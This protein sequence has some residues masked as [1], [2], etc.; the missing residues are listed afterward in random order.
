MRAPPASCFAGA[1]AARQPSAQ[2]SIFTRSLLP[3]HPRPAPTGAIPGDDSALDLLPAAG[4]VTSSEDYYPTVAIN[5]LMRVLRDPGLAALHSKAVASLFDIVRA[6]RLN[7]V[8]YLPKVGGRTRAPAL[9]R[10]GGPGRAGSVL[11]TA[12][13]LG[14]IGLPSPL[15]L[16]AAVLC[17]AVLGWATQPRNVSPPCF[18]LTVFASLPPPPCA[19]TRRWSPCCCS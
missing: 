9:G 3:A 19:R 1:S 17:C 15:P 10:S 8:P 11:G 13:G 14:H 12:L 7:F 2:P 16:P 18:S 5:A 4:L 6:M